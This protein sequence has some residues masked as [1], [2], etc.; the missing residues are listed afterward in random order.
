ML[1]V[2]LDSDIILDVLAKR[3]PYYTNSALILNLAIEKK[4]NAFTSPL[5]FANIHYILNKLNS[6]TSSLE[7]LKS[8]RRFIKICPINEKNIDLALNSEFK[9]FEDAIQNFSAFDKKIN[10]IV[11]RNKSDYKF[12]NLTI[13]NPAE[14]LKT[15]N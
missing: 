2:F 15:Q 1:S 6:K 11:T 13:L 4:I 14:F 5:V 7:S 3:E 10:F 9:D 8:L 12:S